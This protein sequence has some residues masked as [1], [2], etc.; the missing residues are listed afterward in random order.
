MWLHADIQSVPDIVRHNARIRPDATALT[1]VRRTETFAA[2][3]ASTNRVA[4][5]IRARAL[6][7]EPV[8]AFIGKN[9]IPFFEVLFGVTKAGCAILPLNWRLAA[10]ELAAIL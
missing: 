8:V 7:P 3:D 9:S 10:A 6:P 5:A 4:N 2:L 1:Q